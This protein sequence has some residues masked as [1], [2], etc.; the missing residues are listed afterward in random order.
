MGAHRYEISLRLFNSISPEW[1]Y[2]KNL[3]KNRKKKTTLLTNNKQIR[4]LREENPKVR[5]KAEKFKGIVHVLSLK[6]S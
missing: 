2:T 3:R 5:N 1:A 6:Q 4:T